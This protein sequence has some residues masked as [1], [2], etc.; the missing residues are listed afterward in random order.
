MFMFINNADER[1]INV[2]SGA[3]GGHEEIKYYDLVKYKHAEW[4][5]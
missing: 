5:R 3:D 2:H 4:P 1:A